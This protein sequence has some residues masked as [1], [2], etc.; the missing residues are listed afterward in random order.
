MERLSKSLNFP[1]LE[2]IR[3]HLVLTTMQCAS[4]RALI[5]QELEVEPRMSSKSHVVFL[6]AAAVVFARDTV[7]EIK[8]QGSSTCFFAY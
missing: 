1:N 6:R 5:F 7:L 4:G 8:R 2:E 3:E